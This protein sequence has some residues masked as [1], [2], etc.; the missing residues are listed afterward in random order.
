LVNELFES[1]ARAEEEAARAS[2]SSSSSS[3]SSSSTGTP[4]LRNRLHVSSLVTLLE[5]RLNIGIG[6]V[7]GATA[8]AAA[9]G[10]SA[11]ELAEKYGMD[12][13]QLESLVRFVN[14]PSVR[15]GEGVR[16]YVGGAQG[17]E[18][19]AITEVSSLNVFF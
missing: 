19:V 15:E 11:R 7:G 18:D 3:S 14:V 12:A 6:S 9:A 4:L 13:E 8:A 16:R 10:G 17:G 1:R 2:R 5:E